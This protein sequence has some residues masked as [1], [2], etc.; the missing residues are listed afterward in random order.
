MIRTA[1]FNL[2][3]T[4]TRN[5]LNCLRSSSFVL[6]LTLT[7][8][9]QIHAN[10]PF[11][12]KISLEHTCSFFGETLPSDVHTF[13]SDKRAEQVVEKIVKSTGL[14]KNFSIVAA[15]VPNA[16]AVVRFGKRYIFVQPVIFLR[17]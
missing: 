10:E 17:N 4:T 11:N 12:Q 9:V 16:A 8:S 13:A 3:L 6:L 14:P 7:V 5:G 2:K 15:G 1:S